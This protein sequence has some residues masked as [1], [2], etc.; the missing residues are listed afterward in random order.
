MVAR[1]PEAARQLGEGRQARRHRHQRQAVPRPGSRRPR[2]R[3]H[4]HLLGPPR[5]PRFTLRTRTRHAARLQLHHRG[6][7]AVP[8]RRLR[9]FLG[10]QHGTAGR[11]L[12]LHRGR[13]RIAQAPPA[14]AQPRLRPQRARRRRPPNL[15]VGHAR[16]AEDRRRAARCRFE[17]RLHVGR[18][19]LAHHLERHRPLVR[20]PRASQFP[21]HAQACVEGRQPRPRC[22]HAR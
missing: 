18:T 21:H 13:A 15:Y 11:P 16:P 1:P 6:N 8:P 20:Q 17:Q 12:P 9:R 14:R 3:R 4:A 2:G 7:Q 19:F 22:P 5:A 10:R